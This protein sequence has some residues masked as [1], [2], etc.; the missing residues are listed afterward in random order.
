MCPSLK[1][2]KKTLFGTLGGKDGSIKFWNSHEDSN[3]SLETN[4]FENIENAHADW[5]TK[6]S[7]VENNGSLLLVS[8]VLC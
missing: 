1:I 6:L 8:Y 5:I 7:C 4:C 3:G 2:K